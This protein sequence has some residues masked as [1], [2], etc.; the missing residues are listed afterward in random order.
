M[1]AP[2]ARHAGRKNPKIYGNPRALAA[3]AL[4]IDFAAAKNTVQLNGTVLNVVKLNLV[5]NLVLSIGQYIVWVSLLPIVLKNYLSA[6][7]ENRRKRSV[8]SRASKCVIERVS[9]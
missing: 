8:F 3:R 4:C 5:L 6:G 9:Y 1:G 2:R 7:P